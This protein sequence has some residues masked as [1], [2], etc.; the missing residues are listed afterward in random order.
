MTISG[1]GGRAGAENVLVHNTATGNTVDNPVTPVLP[2]EPVTEPMKVG[3]GSPAPV[4]EP[5]LTLPAPVSSS[6]AF[7]V[8]AAAPPDYTPVGVTRVEET[9]ARGETL[10][11]RNDLLESSMPGGLPKN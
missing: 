4:P 5:L 6:P 1:T 7:L 10:W 8:A 11:A 2:R 3:V 9:G